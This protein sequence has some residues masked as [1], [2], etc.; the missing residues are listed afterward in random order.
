MIKH[1]T[2][3]KQEIIEQRIFLIRAKK[4][5]FDKDLAELYGV[6]TGALIQA[7]KRNIQRFPDDFMHQ[8]TRREFMALKSHFVISKGRGGTRKLPF[9]FT[10]HGI[11]MLSSVLNSDKAVEVN[12]QIMRTFTKLRELMLVHKDLRSKIEEMEKKYD[13]RFTLVFNAI[14]RLLDPP[15]K[16]NKAPLGFRP[17]KN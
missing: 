5:M 6:T 15:A 10:E 8:L 11:L 7:V 12:I 17:P 14:R 2:L 13:A 1:L 3:I 16:K 9:A 4:V